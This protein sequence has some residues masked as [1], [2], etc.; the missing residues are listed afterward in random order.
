VHAVRNLIN[1]LV[2]VEDI[3]N[4]DSGLLAFGADAGGIFVERGR[5]CWAA[6]RGLSRRL[7]EIL[8]SYAHD[9]DFD[10]IYERCRNTGKL[11]GET[12][13]EEGYITPRDL[14]VSLRRH[15]AESLLALCHDVH[16]EPVWRSRG[17]RGYAPRFTFRPLDVFLDV[18][19]LTSPELHGTARA[20]LLPFDAPDR[21]GAAFRLTDELVPV[22]AFGDLSVFELWNLGAWAA[23][24]PIASRELGSSAQ[25]AIG[26]TSERDAFAVW[27]RA[28]LLYIVISQDRRAISDVMRHVG[29][30]T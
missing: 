9:T 4:S 6:A 26:G 3:A 30:V 28:D 29:V 11:L 12:L 2:Q 10:A 16:E 8:R 20:E 17:E 27:W 22:A 13:V 18:I 24:L 15:S 7:Q 19:A 1:V 14:E 25:L 23:N 5:I 21:L